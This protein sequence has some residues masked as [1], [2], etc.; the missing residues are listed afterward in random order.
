MTA[1]EWLGFVVAPLLLLAVGIG[2]ALINP[3][4]NRHGW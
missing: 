1:V 4:L 3:W 2:A